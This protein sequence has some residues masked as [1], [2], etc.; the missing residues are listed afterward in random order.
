MRL[1]ALGLLACFVLV[2]CSS[3]VD[4]AEHELTIVE[5]SGGSKDDICKAKT[6][7]AEAY[8]KAQ[9]AQHYQVKKLEADL[10]CNAARLDS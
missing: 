1:I 6:K 10:A 4:N 2:G 8:F 3:E 7:V 9:D 5:Q